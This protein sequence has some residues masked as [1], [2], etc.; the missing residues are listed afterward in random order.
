MVDASIRALGCAQMTQHFHEGQDVEV[1]NL[2]PASS[3]AIW[4]KAK[5]VRMA[6]DGGAIFNPVYETT[7]GLFD[8]AR[9]RAVSP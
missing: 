4:R 8:A 7:L 1:A 6:P 5:I 2:N 9:I 3:W